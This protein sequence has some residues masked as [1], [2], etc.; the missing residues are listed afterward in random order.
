VYHYAGNN[1]VKYVD[2]DGRENEEANS[3]N[4]II[5]YDNLSSDRDGSFRKAAETLSNDYNGKTYM[6]GVRT[7]S[8]F[9]EKWNS[10]S[11]TLNA[12]NEKISNLDILTHGDSKNL[13]LVND[14]RND[15]SLTVDEV[16]NLTQLNFVSSG[17]INLY[18]CNSGLLKD[19]GIG[20]TFADWQ[21]ISVS[22]QY[23]FTAFSTN[24][25]YYSR[26]NPSSSSVYLQAYDRGR[27]N[28]WGKGGAYPPRRYNP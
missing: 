7:E 25:R 13:Y 26:I 8:E 22:G 1:P 24:P 3:V 10:L 12:N 9:K 23:G 4:V 15:G 16:A 2:P 28:P 11:S 17:E 19:K 14:S 27:N 6:I 5:F 21:N 18:S 20:Q